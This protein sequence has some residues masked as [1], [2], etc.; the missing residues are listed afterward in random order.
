[1]NDWKECKRILCVRT[2]N[3]GDVIM[4]GPA[5][6]A[7]KE[8]FKCHITLL[9]SSM[10]S[11]ITHCMEEIDDVIVY[12]VP[13]T[14]TE[15]SPSRHNCLDLIEA[16]R[17]YNFDAAIIFTVYSQSALP[18]AM[19]T[20]MAGIPLRLAY[21]RENPYNLLTH[22]VPDKEPYS[23]IYH[24]VE[25]D[26][27]LVAYT[28]AKTINNSLS[29]SYGLKAKQNALGK[30]VELGIDTSK[31]VI[32]LH[33]GVSEKKREYPVEL[34]IETGKLLGDYFQRQILI[35][36]GEKEKK[37]ANEIKLGIGSNAFSSSGKLTVEEFA[38]VI[39]KALFVVSV[40]TSA[41]HIAAALQTPL[42][43]LYALTN[44]QHIPWKSIARVLTFKVTDAL[45]SKN[46]VVN[47]VSENLMNDT[48]GYPLPTTI[49]ETAKDLLLNPSSA[50]AMPVKMLRDITP[51]FQ[52]PG[53]F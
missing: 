10:G 27:N 31:Q 6:R 44:P 46:E 28:G 42:I 30:L 1:M 19:I 4:T 37:L 34:W 16:L 13:W 20:M 49:L 48:D 25:R 5:L 8:T 43:V 45:E 52:E 24:Q 17:K 7:L 41:V 11:L 50:C 35:T 47:F 14:K 29:V 53:I 9:T 36:A 21:C 18:A 40:N 12:D 38:A 23:V 26:L 32:I 39:D 22:W 15:A 3:M 51:F 33:P 2:D